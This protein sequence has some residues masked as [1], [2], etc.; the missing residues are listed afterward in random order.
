MWTFGYPVSIFYVCLQ[1]QE[2]EMENAKL[3]DDLN[4]LRKSI[5]DSEPQNNRIQE[6]MSKYY[7]CIILHMLYI[8]A[9]NCGRPYYIFVDTYI[10]SGSAPTMAVDLTSNSCLSWH[11]NISAIRPTWIHSWMLKYSSSL[12]FSNANV[13]KLLDDGVTKCGGEE[14][15]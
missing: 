10:I 14:M 5:A 1:L 9:S 8:Y 15:V 3:K 13:A 4:R 12:P 11:L 7:I 6:F 2:L